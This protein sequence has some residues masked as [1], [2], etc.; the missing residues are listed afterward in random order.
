MDVLGIILALAGLGYMY[1]AI[2]DMLGFGRTLLL[3]APIAVYF[4]VTN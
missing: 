4:F 1:Q 3:L 2:E